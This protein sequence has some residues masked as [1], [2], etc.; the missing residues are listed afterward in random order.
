VV[1]I[2]RTE[3]QSRSVLLGTGVA[4]AERAPLD[5]LVMSTL[6][7]TAMRALAGDLGGRGITA[8][9][10]TLSGASTGA[11]AG[12]L[13]IMTAGD[14]AVVERARPVLEAMGSNLFHVGDDVGTAQA[15]KLAVQLAFGV[16][17]LGAFEALSLAA[18]YG[19]DEAQ[20]MSILA[21]SV[22]DSWVARNWERV[23]GWWEDY[24]PGQAST[25]SSRTCAR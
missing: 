23:R 17:M 19:V 13:T 16:N 2:V 24:V 14:P 7:P 8:I 1:S 6:D 3:E 15:A 11:K 25:S 20:L 18:A 9:D 5:V 22:G 21:L 10:A 12:T 4:A